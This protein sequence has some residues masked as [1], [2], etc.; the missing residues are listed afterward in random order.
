V[1]RGIPLG[2]RITGSDWMEGGLDADDAVA[3]TKGLQ[4]A[5]FDFVC[6]SSGGVS[7]E[8]RNPTAPGYNAPLAEQVRRET[9][10]A[11]RVV[12]LIA[13]PRQAEALVAEGKADMVALARAMLH[14]PHWGWHAAL[15]LGAD[16]ARPPQYQRTA[17]KLWPG[18]ASLD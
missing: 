16:V 6:V 12:G 18:A 4:G 5:G 8:A 14:N 3:F 10:I 11:T 13:T 9:G 1:P 7:A 17:P 2:A 15:D